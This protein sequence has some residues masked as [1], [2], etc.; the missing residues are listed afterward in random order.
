VSPGALQPRRV[1]AD[2]SVF[3]GVFDAEFDAHSKAFFDQVRAGRFRLVISP[4]IERELAAA[5]DQVRAWYT[6]FSGLSESTLVTSESLQLQA[7][8][9][10]AGI[11][12]ERSAEDALHVALATV[13]L[14]DILVS[15]NF[16][17]IVHVDKGPKYNAVNAL[18]G[19]RDLAIHSPAEVVHYEEDL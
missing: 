18:R 19:Y 1:Y 7:S 15:W 8:Y 2:T 6:D 16:K 17:H 11:V 14:C 13:S 12:S 10:S 9:L 5:P 3:G 4:V